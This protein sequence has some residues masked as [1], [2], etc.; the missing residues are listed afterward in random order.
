[1]FCERQG[2]SEEH[3]LAKWL[4]DALGGPGPFGFKLDRRYGRGK[5]NLTYLGVTTRAACQT[6]NNGWMSQFEQTAK[7]LLIPI[8]RDQPAMWDGDEQLAV[9]RWAFKTALMID[10]T[11]QPERRTVPEAHFRYLFEHRKPPPAATI[12]L[13]RYLP[14]KGEVPFA[15]W[16]NTSWAAAQGKSEEIE[17]YKITVSVGHAIFQVYAHAHTER[18]GLIFESVIHRNDQPVADAFR[19]LWPASPAAAFEWPPQG[20]HFSTSGFAFLADDTP[21]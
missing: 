20:A 13:A 10:R 6:C 18:E 8:I 2:S 3:V 15:A 9:A 1:V 16:M 14:Q 17:G 11:N 5:T 19:R 21:A 12:A 7:P 4:T